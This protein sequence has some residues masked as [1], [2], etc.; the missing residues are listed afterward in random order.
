MKIA[1]AMLFA[2]FAFAA[3]AAP[4]AM[5][6][7]ECDAF[8]DYALVARA[9]VMDGLDQERRVAILVRIYNARSDSRTVELMRSINAAAKASKSKEAFGF[10]SR[11]LEACYLNQGNMDSVLGVAL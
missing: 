4:K 11:L 2:L 8:A 9:L 7:Q 6:P 1:I 3:V 10:A 5:S